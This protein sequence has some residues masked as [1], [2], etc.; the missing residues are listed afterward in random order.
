MLGICL[1]AIEDLAK[2]VTFEEI[3]H[4][5]QNMMRSYACSLLRC[6]TEGADDVLQEA[7]LGIARNIDR[8]CL[9]DP[10]ALR[11]YVMV[12]VRNTV[13]NHQAKEARENRA[14]QQLEEEMERY[15]PKASDKVLAEVCRR[16]RMQQI[17]MLL[18]Q[19]PPGCREVLEL[20]Y[21]CRMELREIAGHLGLSYNAVQK[22]YRRGND[23]LAEGL[24]KGGVDY[25]DE[26]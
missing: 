6:T 18:R 22:R 12:T 3:Y 2:R 15:E 20:H 5:Y 4:T 21:V 10:K 23:L 7:F 11:S 25:G 24:R 19:L 13:R 17:V 8:V 1:M 14:R 26:Q 16:E 9:L